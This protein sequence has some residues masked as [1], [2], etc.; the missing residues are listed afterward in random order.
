MV[1]SIS[2]DIEGIRAEGT[3]VINL[4]YR[5]SET[6]IDI[7]LVVETHVVHRLNSHES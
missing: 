7:D 1:K 4:D 6:D 5:Y 3:R 2:T